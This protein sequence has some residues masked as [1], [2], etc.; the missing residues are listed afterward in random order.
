M[1]FENVTTLELANQLNDL[2][3]EESLIKPYTVELCNRLATEDDPVLESL[4]T[5]E[6]VIYVAIKGVYPKAA[7]IAEL[8]RA[9]LAA[10]RKPLSPETIWVH[11]RRIREKLG[12]GIFETVRGKGYRFVMDSAGG[13]DEQ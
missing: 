10:A 5:T 1:N 3:Q 4:T 6:A 2:V 13:E 7:S 8:Q 11:I 12:E 9:A